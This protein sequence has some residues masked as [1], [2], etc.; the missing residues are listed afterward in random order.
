MA[1]P[2]LGG[3]LDD[4]IGSVTDLVSEAVV[5]KDK[6]NEINLELAKLSDRANERLHEQM[7]AQSST[8]TEEAKHRSI[9][10]A[11]WRPAI[12]WGCGVA[13]VYNTLIAPMFNL[14][15][16]D[17]AFLQTVL[18]GMLGIAGMRSFDKYAGTANDVLPMGKEKGPE[19]LLPPQYLPEDTPWMK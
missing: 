16:A 5:D 9:F 2:I 3:I 8:N 7:L 19:N 1:I 10:V 18:M 12:G 17:L 13:L 4:V 11:G 6:R 14:G 15:Q